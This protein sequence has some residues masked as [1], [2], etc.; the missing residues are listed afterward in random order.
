MPDADIL[1][2]GGGTVG[3]AAAAALGAAG[4]KVVLIERG[5]P[6]PAF[7]LG[8]V[9]ARV[10]AL[11]P[12]SIRLLTR[13]GVW[14]AIAAARHSPYR[15][16]QVWHDDADRALRFDAAPDQSLGSIVEHGLLNAALWAQGGDWLR[17]SNAVISSVSA[18]EDEGAAVSLQD[19]RRLKAKLLVIADG[20]D[21]PLRAQLGIDSIGWDYAQRAVVAHVSTA[22]PHGGIARQRFLPTGPLALLPLVDGRCSLVWS[23]PTAMAEDLL[24]LD[25]AAFGLRLSTASAQTLGSI[26]AVTPRRSFPLRLGHVPEPVVPA[27]VVIGDAAHVI[28]PLAGQGVNLGLADAEVLA[29]TLAAARDAQR[30][31]WR[32]RTLKAY[33]RARRP[34][35]LEMLAMTDGLSRAFTSPAALRR[36]LGD[37]MAALDRAGPVKQW[38]LSRA[39]GRS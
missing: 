8:E 32:E 10:Y 35:T 5:A 17:L 36:L 37:G 15:A 13:L 20:P 34:E 27:A 3:L 18:A 6:P 11:S 29:A 24:A 30:G 14:P 25:D 22:L 39:A 23:C 28:H 33:A 2:A 9:D 4:F 38:L 7:E 21:S 26:G 1:I 19:G 12:A 31:W 16:M